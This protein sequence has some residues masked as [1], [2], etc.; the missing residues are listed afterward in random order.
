MTL[1]SKQVLPLQH[2]QTKIWLALLLAHQP[3]ESSRWLQQLQTLQELRPQLQ[4]LPP[5]LVRR[6]VA[7]VA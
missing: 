2:R 5:W 1:S 7:Q 4:G 6:L 3:L